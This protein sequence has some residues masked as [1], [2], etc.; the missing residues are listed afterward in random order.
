MTYVETF[1]PPQFCSLFFCLKM[2][3]TILLS[4][5]LSWIILSD[6]RSDQSCIFKAIWKSLILYKMGLF[7]SHFFLFIY[8]L[9]TLLSILISFSLQCPCQNKCGVNPEAACMTSPASVDFFN[10]FIERI[11]NIWKFLWGQIW[12]GTYFLTT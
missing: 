1:I 8:F 6:D 3:G 9:S 2:E 5:F 4:A 11:W 10:I 12:K 7:F